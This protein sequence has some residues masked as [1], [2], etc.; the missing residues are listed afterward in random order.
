MS[1][2]ILQQFDESLLSEITDSKRA[3]DDVEVCRALLKRRENR[4]KSLATRK[5]SFREWLLILIAV[6]A[7]TGLL[8]YSVS[9]TRQLNEVQERLSRL[10]SATSARPR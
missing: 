10:E 2:H 6:V 5:L 4:M 3:G 8:F 9:V 7:V 1:Y